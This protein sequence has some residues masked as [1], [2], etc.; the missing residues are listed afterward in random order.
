M[1]DT[2]LGSQ[3]KALQIQLAVLKAQV[4]SLEPH[5]GAPTLGDLYGALAG[6][7]TFSD[8]EI[9]DA[10]FHFEWDDTEDRGS[11]A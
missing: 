4:E 10:R 5:E 7:G 9:S 3:F 6:S 2:T 1:G 8:K 11:V